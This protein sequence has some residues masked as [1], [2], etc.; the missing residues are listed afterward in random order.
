M[1][2]DAEVTERE[3]QLYGSVWARNVEREGTYLAFSEWEW[4][5]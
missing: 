3:C 1:Q 4:E 5:F 2:V